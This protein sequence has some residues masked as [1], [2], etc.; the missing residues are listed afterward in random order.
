MDGHFAKQVVVLP[1]KNIM[2]ANVD[3][4]MQITLRP[5]ANAGFAVP[6][7]AQ[8]RA[9]I[10][11]GRDADFDFAALLDPAF[12]PAFPTG[13]SDDPARPVTARAGGRHGKKSPRM[14]HLTAPVTG[15]TGF[16]PGSGGAPAPGAVRARVKNVECDFLFAPA[17]RFFKINF[18]VVTEIVAAPHLFRLAGAIPKKTIKNTAARPKNCFKNISTG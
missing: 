4:D 17:G 5:A 14:G 6:G 12:A 16:V 11:P 18:K 8:P 3:Y 15:G 7:T 10:N 9:I 1:N 13:V 2:F